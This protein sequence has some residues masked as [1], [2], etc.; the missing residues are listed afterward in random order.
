MSDLKN[1]PFCGGKASYLLAWGVKCLDCG[2]GVP[3][4]GND[5]T[6]WSRRAPS[7]TPAPLSSLECECGMMGPCMADDCKAPIRR[8]LTIRRAPARDGEE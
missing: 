8:G 7:P 5:F 2:A 6:A 4:F 1:C 3:C